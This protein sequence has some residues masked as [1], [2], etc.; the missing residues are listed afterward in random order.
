[1]PTIGQLLLLF[2]AILAFAIGGGMS[3]ARAWSDHPMPR[4]L[5]RILLVVGILACAGV[6]IWHSAYRHAWLPVGDNFDALVWL[7]TLLALFVLYVQQRQRLGALDW[8]VM[9]LVIVLLVA[10]AIC[11]TWAWV[12]RVTAYGGAVAFAIAAAA[13]AM[14]ILASK[15]L[16]DKSPVG[17]QFGSLEGLEHLTLTSV[18]LGFALLTVGMITGVVQMF[19]EGKHTPPFKIVLAL[20]VWLVYGVVLHAPYN[21]RFRGRKVAVLSMVGFVLMLGTII[22]VLALPASSS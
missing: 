6:I 18:T 3:A 10:A 17:P 4:L 22:A 11:D 21:P 16:R 14:Y 2:S 1:M 13:G 5:S 12:H 15:R 7:A 19:G 8:F 9:P 20:S